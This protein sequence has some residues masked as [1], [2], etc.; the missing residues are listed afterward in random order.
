[1]SEIA[2]ELAP[3]LSPEDIALLRRY[4]SEA[5]HFSGEEWQRLRQVIR[6]LGKS[7]VQFGHRRYHFDRFYAVFIDTT[8][9][10]PF[11]A[12]L[13]K[14]ADVE[15]DGQRWQAQTARKIMAWMSLNGVRAGEVR[16]AEYLIVFCLYRWAAFAKGY[17]FET[18]ILHD[19]AATGIQMEAHEPDR[20]EER[21]SRFDLYIPGLGVGDV[22]ASPYFLD[23]LTPAA[24]PADFYITRLYD[25][26]QRRFYLATFLLEDAWRR[27]DMS[28]KSN[29]GQRWSQG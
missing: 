16:D 21:Y 26:H 14:A 10:H 25:T 19:L 9:A 4:L 8:Y 12:R 28:L 23:D 6:Q 3:Y 5:L 29:S 2:I 1:M 18:T 11:L 7:T 15:R 22:K 17:I 13:S 27:I 24:R 20:G